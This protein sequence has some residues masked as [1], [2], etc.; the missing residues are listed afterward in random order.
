M[1]E[2][3]TFICTWELAEVIAVASDSGSVF[4]CRFVLFVSNLYLHGL[5]LSA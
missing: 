3:S 5:I 4:K 1:K 2:L